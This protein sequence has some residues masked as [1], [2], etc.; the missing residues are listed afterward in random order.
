[1][2]Y[3]I[4][5][6][7]DNM[8]PRHLFRCK[9]SPAKPH[10][11]KIIKDIKNKLFWEASGRKEF[12]VD[13]KGGNQPSRFHFRPQNIDLQKSRFW[14][15]FARN[16]FVADPKGGNR[17]P[18]FYFRPQNI[19]LQKNS[20]CYVFVWNSFVA[21][22]KGGIDPLDFISDLKTSSC[23]NHDFAMFLQEIHPLDFLSCL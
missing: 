17:P 19:K 12:V 1:M 16:S 11:D 7:A 9:R 2:N 18:R 4:N 3:S 23:K 10:P 6:L 22:P 15:V 14:Y 21:D 13:P 20:F 5:D 8:A